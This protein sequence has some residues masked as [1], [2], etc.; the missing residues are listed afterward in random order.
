PD[1]TEE[2]E[3]ELFITIK[4][5]KVLPPEELMASD[6]EVDADGL[7]TDQKLAVQRSKEIVASLVLAW[8]MYD[9]TGFGL[10][11]EGNPKDQLPLPL[12]ATPELV[13]KLPTEAIQ[14]INQT[15]TE[16]IN[17]T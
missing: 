13:G 12:P 6:I 3:P 1:L 10:D 14:K 16:S 15:I 5:P 4:N 2:G 9:A 7:P 17:P 11:E 8:R